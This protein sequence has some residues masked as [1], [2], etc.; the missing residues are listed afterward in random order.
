M[1]K[2][3]KTSTKKSSKKTR[4][5]DTYVET[6]EFKEIKKILRRLRRMRFMF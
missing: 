1:A 2:L 5:S 4:D 3:K 6:P